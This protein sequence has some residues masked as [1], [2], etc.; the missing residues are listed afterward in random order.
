MR[1]RIN[2]HAN[3]MFRQSLTLLIYL[4]AYQYISSS[5][6]GIKVD[7]TQQASKESEFLAKPSCRPLLRVRHA[8]NQYEGK[9]RQLFFLLSP[10]IPPSSPFHCLSPSPSFLLSLLSFLSSPLPSLPP[11]LYLH[12]FI[13][14]PSFLFSSPSIYFLLGKSGL[15]PKKQQISR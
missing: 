1:V 13:V 7:V 4:A 15:F 11:S 2:Y 12:S 10:S 5:N 9:K 14:L 3:F 6:Y 8:D